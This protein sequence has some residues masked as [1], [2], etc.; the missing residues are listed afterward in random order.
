MDVDSPE[1]ALPPAQRLPVEILSSIFDFSSPSL[2]P[3][4][5]R[6]RRDILAED[7]T[8]RAAELARC[9]SVCRQWRAAVDALGEVH[10]ETLTT[11]SA[12]ANRGRRASTL[13]V[14]V[15]EDEYSR[16]GS[17]P[18]WIVP[19]VD[20]ATL[21]LHHP[22]SKQKPP[23]PFP[24]PELYRCHL[25]E[26]VL[27]GGTETCVNYAWIEPLLQDVPTLEVLRLPH[28]DNP[29]IVHETAL[30]LT[31]LQLA[32]FFEYD[33]L[34]LH[35]LL[36]R[37]KRL[38]NLHLTDVPKH[39]HARME[40]EPP[41]LLANLPS[42]LADFLSQITSF[43]WLLVPRT[44]QLD[45]L[46]QLLERLK[47]VRYLETGLGA[48]RDATFEHLPKLV[49]LRNLRLVRHAD[50]P[51]HDRDSPYWS[52]EALAEQTALFLNNDERDGQVLRIDVQVEGTLAKYDVAQR[53][54]RK[55]F[56]QAMQGLPT[57]VYLLEIRL[58][59]YQ[60]P[61]IAFP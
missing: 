49:H 3:P 43:S 50:T 55:S 28:V 19:D 12:V 36:P 23:A 32:I 38:R 1:D 46:P 9:G 57:A 58:H 40:H 6:P 39:V 26:V 51:A 24:C 33:N 37:A 10:F 18:L 11:A 7:E 34:L 29:S 56:E 35:N 21:A 54:A 60:K 42:V 30:D 16:W 14:N 53:S 45:I 15:W 13:T 4:P 44:G 48:F 2:A 5:H 52:F 20:S 22:L 25:R 61:Y 17:L 59:F 8:E 47:Q 27:L 31:T 41:E